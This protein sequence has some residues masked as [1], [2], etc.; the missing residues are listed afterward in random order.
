MNNSE[1]EVKYDFNDLHRYKFT[2]ILVYSS[3]IKTEIDETVSHN[4]ITYTY[5]P[6]IVSKNIERNE[7]SR[8]PVVQFIYF[9]K[10][11]FH[12]N[13]CELN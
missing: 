3:W 12:S 13:F 1:E 7:K 8:K 4:L 11:F 10:F 9:K 6:Y 5:P 2:M